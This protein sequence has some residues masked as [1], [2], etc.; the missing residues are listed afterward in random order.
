MQSVKRKIQTNEVLG[1]AELEALDV[2]KILII[3]SV[4][5]TDPKH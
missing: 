4:Y 2:P 3:S 1:G 5:S